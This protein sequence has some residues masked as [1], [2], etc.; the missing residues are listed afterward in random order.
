[1]V[2]VCTKEGAAK[3][4]DRNHWRRIVKDLSWLT[5]FG[6]SLCVP[7]VLFLLGAWWLTQHGFGAWVYIPALVLGLGTSA[8]SFRSFLRYIQNR[9]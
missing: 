8:S 1:M 4:L 2:K 9:K 7:P 3:R 6:V 5:Q